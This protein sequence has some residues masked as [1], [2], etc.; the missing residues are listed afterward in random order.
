MHSKTD[1]QIIF[2]Q[3]ISILVR[4]QWAPVL[5]PPPA[6]NNPLWQACNSLPLVWFTGSF[7]LDFCTKSYTIAPICTLEMTG[8]FHHMCVQ[9]PPE[10]GWIIGTDVNLGC[11]KQICFFFLHNPNKISGDPWWKGGV[12]VCV[13]LFGRKNPD[14]CTHVYLNQTDKIWH[15]IIKQAIA[16]RITTVCSPVLLCLQ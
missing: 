14:L 12:C 1:M 8:Y 4:W 15:C 3:N 11:I 13:Q 6:S 16:P 5:F 10:V 9:R 7:W 2:C